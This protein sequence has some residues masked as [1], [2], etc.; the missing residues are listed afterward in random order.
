MT[1]V[2]TGVAITD[3]VMTDGAI[4][5]TMITDAV[6]TSRGR[7]RGVLL[8]M[9]FDTSIYQCVSDVQVTWTHQHHLSDDFIWSEVTT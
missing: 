3:T 6:I 9:H 2:V 7:D 1:G 5:D 4:T 8:H